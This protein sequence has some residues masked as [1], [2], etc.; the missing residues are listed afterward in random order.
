MEAL[1]C[2]RRNATRQAR[3]SFG[4]VRW[5]YTERMLCYRYHGDEDRATTVGKDKNGA[6]FY[7]GQL[8]C[9]LCINDLS[10]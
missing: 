8:S 2:K 6:D 7:S 9:D 3:F 5:N 4:V 1:G 10:R